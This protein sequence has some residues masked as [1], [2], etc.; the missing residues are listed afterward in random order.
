MVYYFESDVVQPPVVLFM[1][2]DKHE[3]EDLI[4]WGWPEDIW[5]HVDK[6][7]SA[8]VYL[9]LA[10]GQSIDDVPSSVLDDAAQLVKANSIEGNKVN[11]IDVVYTMWANLK[12]TPGMEVGQ[13]GFHKEKEV[14]K[15]HVPK[16]INTIVNRLNKTKRSETPNLRALR[17]QRD[18][19]EREDKKKLQR[20]LREKE[21]A[22]KKQREEEAEIKSYS[23]LFSHSKMTA[24]TE[25]GY[26]SD[27]FM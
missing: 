16:R 9:R 14:R 15:I 13:V 23:S 17:E 3:N 2:V 21:K 8:H 20:E 19:N 1:G 6:F 18:R 11:D 12:K 24:N 7:S 27:D 4:K 10:P 5:F 22:E 25:A 26:D